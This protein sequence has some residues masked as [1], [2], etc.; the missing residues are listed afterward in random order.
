MS[1]LW[2]NLI[3]KQKCAGFL[4]GLLIY[5][6]LVCMCMHACM[7]EYVSVA[8]PFLFMHS[9]M[10]HNAMAGPWVC[11]PFVTFVNGLS[12][13][14]W[15][16]DTIGVL[17]CGVNW[18]ERCVNTLLLPSLRWKVSWHVCCPHSFDVC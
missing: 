8:V 18:L 14:R 7:C 16:I 17:T 3:W 9:F 1:D 11:C 13:P 10:W 2:Y 5:N 6:G 15:D 4:L 12:E